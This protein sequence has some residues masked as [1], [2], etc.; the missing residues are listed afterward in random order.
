MN[1]SG[2]DSKALN[3]N[4]TALNGGATSKFF[5]EIGDFSSR[6]FF[7]QECLSG[8]LQDRKI[9]RNSSES[10]NNNI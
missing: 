1:L 2:S 8:T 4:W 9:Q 10:I 6:F 7:T 5:S 3:V